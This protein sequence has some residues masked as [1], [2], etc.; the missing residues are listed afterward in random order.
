MRASISGRQPFFE[1]SVTL[2]YTRF[3]RITIPSR[4]VLLGTWFRDGSSRHSLDHIGHT[5]KISRSGVVEDYL[6][7]L[8]CRSIVL[9]VVA[10]V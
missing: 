10:F 7:V 8:R 2:Y 5:S 3:F 9:A 1:R 6:D 4:V